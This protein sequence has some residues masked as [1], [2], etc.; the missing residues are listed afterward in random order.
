MLGGGSSLLAGFD[1]TTTERG[2]AMTIAG[3]VAL[4]GGAIT[5]AIGLSLLRLSQILQVLQIGVED[6]T[7]EVST[8]T[9][10]AAPVI[11]AES[12]PPPVIP[13][14]LPNE[15]LKV[16]TEDTIL[17]SPLKSR[18][19]VEIP[20]KPG[21]FKRSFSPV[22]TNSS[23]GTL[24]TA[25][26]A[27]AG[28]AG[29]AIVAAGA[30]AASSSK[31]SFTQ[32]LEKEFEIPAANDAETPQKMQDDASSLDLEAE[33]SRALAEDIVSEDIASEDMTASDVA[34]AQSVEPLEEEKSAEPISFNEG[35]TKVLSK[36]PKRGKRASLAAETAPEKDLIDT[37]VEDFALLNDDN[38]EP[39]EEAIDPALD[40]TILAEINDQKD[41]PNGNAEDDTD[42]AAIQNNGPTILGT[43]N[44]GNGTYVMYSDGTVAATT[45]QG[46]RMFKSM[47]E[48]RAHLAET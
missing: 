40:T 30:A 47:E 5:V 1:I 8:P 19:Q 37:S 33:L 31:D 11:Q 25:G 20:K 23:K 22:E 41:E 3:T 2:A 24:A 43:Y 27:T 28:L 26:L 45:E 39:A 21:F 7:P 35:L 12:A 16:E 34:E 46:V 6:E 13:V 4:A 32:E 48:L 9:A 14:S 15:G 42:A 44:A 18:D 29:A 36:P 17:T 38:V 10:L